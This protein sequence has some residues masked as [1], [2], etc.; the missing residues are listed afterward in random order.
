[1]LSN[2]FQIFLRKFLTF[3]FLFF[4][5]FWITRAIQGSPIESLFGDEIP[6]WKKKELEVQLNLKTAWYTQAT[7]YL[8]KA[9]HLDLGESLFLNK[10]VIVLIQER[11]S[12]SFSFAIISE[13]CA[14]I[15]ALFLTFISGKIYFSKKRN[16]ELYFSKTLFLLQP[17]PIFLWAPLFIQFFG[18][19]FKIFQFTPST[20]QNSIFL[21]NLSAFPLAVFSFSVARGLTLFPIYRNDLFININKDFV[22]TAKAKGL[23]NSQILLRHLFPVQFKKILSISLVQISTLLLG[24]VLVESIFQI[25]GLGKLFIDSIFLRDY[26]LIQ[27]FSLL[28]LIITLIVSLSLEILNGQKRI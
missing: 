11:A 20:N 26:P 16:S 28:F 15:L 25:Q 4:F 1:M 13:F 5:F 22:R 2:N 18:V 12:T 24:A 8:S 6:D 19:Y 21:S 17:I 7:S 14:S 23:T 10:P 9:I 27:G 3:F